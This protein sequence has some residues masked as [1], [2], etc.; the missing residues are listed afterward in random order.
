MVEV[1]VTLKFISNLWSVVPEMDWI[2][3]TYD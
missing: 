2:H 3:H 1:S